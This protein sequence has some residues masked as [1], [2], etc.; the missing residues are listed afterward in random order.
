MD[1]V[2]ALTPHA[3][4]AQGPQVT[5]FFGSLKEELTQLAQACQ[6][7]LVRL[8]A[9]V[10]KHSLEQ[11]YACGWRVNVCVLISMR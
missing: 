2:G 4:Q 9:A 11:P 6:Q 7:L 1:V 8:R 5:Y 3:G 10:Q